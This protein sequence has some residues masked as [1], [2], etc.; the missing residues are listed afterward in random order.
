MLC[1]AILKVKERTGR[2]SRFTRAETERVLE[3]KE[4]F[5][6]GGKITTEDILELEELLQVF[7]VLA[8]SLGN[9]VKCLRNWLIFT[10]FFRRQNQTA[11]F[12]V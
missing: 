4:K 10:Q 9:I 8:N 6:P 1:R 11:S 5:R 3:L 12:A 7:S 2:I